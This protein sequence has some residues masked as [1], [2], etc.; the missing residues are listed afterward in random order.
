[1]SNIEIWGNSLIVHEI[2]SRNIL[3]IVGGCY[4]K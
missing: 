3:R 2:D 1:M 4:G